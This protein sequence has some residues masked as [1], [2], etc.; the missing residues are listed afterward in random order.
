VGCDGAHRGGPAF[1]TKI[2]RFNRGKLNPKMDPALKLFNVINV[3]SIVCITKMVYHLKTVGRV[4]MR[5][6]FDTF[7]IISAMCNSPSSPSRGAPWTRSSKSVVDSH[8]HSHANPHSNSNL[9]PNSPQH[10]DLA[11][12]SGHVEAK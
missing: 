10:P 3:I 8:S 2:T 9:Y 11:R 1:V 4:Y 12:G 5:N 6:P 7:S